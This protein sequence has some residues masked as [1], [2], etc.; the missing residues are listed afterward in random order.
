MQTFALAVWV[1]EGTGML[2]LTS[3][4]Q[5]VLVL[6]GSWRPSSSSPSPPLL[7]RRRRLDAGCV[8]ASATTLALLLDPGLK[9]QTPAVLLPSSSTARPSEGSSLVTPFHYRKILFVR[10]F[11][12]PS[13]NRQTT[14][15]LCSSTLQQVAQETSFGCAWP[16]KT[17]PVSLVVGCEGNQVLFKGV[18]TASSSLGMGG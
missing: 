14:L 7:T 12:H 9:G 17:I 18:T 4:V 10:H 8:D 2:R 11:S 15:K 16:L 1:P 5:L 6:Q 3:R 13:G